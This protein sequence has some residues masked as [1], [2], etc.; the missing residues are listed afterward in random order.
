[1][2]AISWCSAR[3]AAEAAARVGAGLVSIATRSS[4]ASLLSAV[5]PEIMSHGVESLDALDALDQAGVGDCNR[6][7]LGS[8]GMG[9]TIICTCTRITASDRHRC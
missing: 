2:K 6:S 5:R 9:Q 3:M 8:V 1:M 7:R 4:H